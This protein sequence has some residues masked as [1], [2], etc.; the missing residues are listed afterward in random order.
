M[1]K[2]N[3]SRGEFIGL[4]KFTDKGVKIIKQV[5]HDLIKKYKKEDWKAWLSP[6]KCKK[7]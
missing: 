2:I 3:E 7:Q 1:V 4:A 6:I 5:Y